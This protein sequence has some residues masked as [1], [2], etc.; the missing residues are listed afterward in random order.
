MERVATCQSPGPACAKRDVFHGAGRPLPYILRALATAE[1]RTEAPLSNHYGRRPLSSG[2]PGQPE[3]EV[4]ER[5]FSGVGPEGPGTSGGPGNRA[6]WQCNGAYEG[7]G[8][9]RIGS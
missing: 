3:P 9:E 7:A 6:E 4:S 2:S 1:G 5:A 8:G